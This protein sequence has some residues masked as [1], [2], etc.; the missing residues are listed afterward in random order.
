MVKY[1]LMIGLLSMTTVAVAQVFEQQ[2]PQVKLHELQQLELETTNQR[3]NLQRI[4]A[5]AL[6]LELRVPSQYTEKDREN[7]FTLLSQLKQACPDCSTGGTVGGG[8]IIGGN[9][10]GPPLFPIGGG[11]RGG[12]IPTVTIT[13]FEYQQ[14]KRKAALYDSSVSEAGGNQ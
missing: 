11:N 8:I 2:V 6:N 10:G 3:F 12:L 1:K 14:L 9:S 13:K 4:S 5:D 7:I